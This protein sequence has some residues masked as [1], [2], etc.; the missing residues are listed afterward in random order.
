M[1]NIIIA[2]DREHLL[3]L[4]KAHIEK[5]GNKCN[6]NHIDVSCIT[7]M[8]DLFCHS[9]FNGDISQ[10]NT[11]NV[12]DMRNMFY[13]S[14]FN[15]D[16]SQWNVE[17]VTDMSYM[18]SHSFFN[19]DIASWE[20]DSVKNMQGVFSNSQFN[21]DI[22]RWNLSSVEDISFMFSES[23]FCGDITN[24]NVANVSNINRL[25]EYCDCLEIP[26]WATIEDFS[27]RKQ[28]VLVYQE[29]K[30]N[31]QLLEDIVSNQSPLKII[32]KI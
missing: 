4:I 1:K 16:I 19:G 32:H 11:A 12:T 27:T 8:R 26:Y 17:N 6:L 7:N 22:S 3:K 29:I 13:D 23:K 2:K 21:G 31:K 10:W 30:K 5:E 28:A 9:Q 20:V 18:F 24:W 25:F 15:G 14:R